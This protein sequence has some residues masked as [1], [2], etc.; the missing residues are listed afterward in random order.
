[1]VDSGSYT[2]IVGLWVVC[3]VHR[4]LLALINTKQLYFFMP[5]QRDNEKLYF[6][7]CKRY[8]KGRATNVSRS[9]YQRHAPLRDSGLSDTFAMSLSNARTPDDLALS[10]G[11]HENTQIRAGM[12]GAPEINV[13][14][15]TSHYAIEQFTLTD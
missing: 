12:A 15:S 8:C 6:C 7:N 2:N 9:T 1:M 3:N 13:C 11:I 14:D 5:P 4:C 10:R